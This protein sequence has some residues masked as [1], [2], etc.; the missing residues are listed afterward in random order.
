MQ[1][2]FDIMDPSLFNVVLFERL[3]EI[4]WIFLSTKAELE[5]FV[6]R[7]EDESNASNNEVSKALFEVH[8]FR[9]WLFWFILLILRLLSKVE[10]FVARHSVLVGLFEPLL[11]ALELLPF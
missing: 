5:I 6:I 10:P 8:W 7:E 3:L 2:D 11:L 4:L 9:W 1:I